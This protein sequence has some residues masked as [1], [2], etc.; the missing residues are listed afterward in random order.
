MHIY[1]IDI[2]HSPCDCIVTWDYLKSECHEMRLIE[3]NN[4]ITIKY[5]GYT[6]GL[7]KYICDCEPTMQLCLISYQMHVL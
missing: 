1:H 6:F 4:I 7:Q 2:F 3:K 5:F